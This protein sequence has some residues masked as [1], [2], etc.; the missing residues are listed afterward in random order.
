[1]RDSFQSKKQNWLQLR[2]TL[3]EKQAASVSS[4]ASEDLTFQIEEEKA[5]E[6]EVVLLQN[7][8]N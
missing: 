7:Q 2:N 3:A 4:M 1:V 8:L 6:R 5:G